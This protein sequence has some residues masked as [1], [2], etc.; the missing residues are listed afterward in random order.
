MKYLKFIASALALTF[1]LSE[2]TLAKNQTGTVRTFNSFDG[3]S[4]LGSGNVE[5]IH[6][7]KNE[8]I[9][10]APNDLIPYLITEVDNGT[11]KIG[12][13]KKG[14]KKFKYFMEEIGY[15]ITVKDIDHLK[16]SGSGDINADE[17]NGKNCKIMISGSGEIDV[18]KIDAGK[19][20]VGLSGSGDVEVENVRA[21]NIDVGISGS[22]DI[23]LEGKTNELEISISG[24]GD[25]NGSGLKSDIAT[26]NIYGSGDA[27]F[28]CSGMLEAHLTG[29][30]DIVCYGNPSIRSHST[31]SG[32][33]ITQ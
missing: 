17:L 10:H 33:I 23:E 3:I 12:K 22:G 29:S 8:V 28:G 1:I 21:K 26:V 25:F 31:G 7:N 4:L 14:W 9:I 6:G 30:G 11:L 18:E 20:D 13:R 32:S 16:I 19:L 24:S 27:S 15:K 2:I 5:I